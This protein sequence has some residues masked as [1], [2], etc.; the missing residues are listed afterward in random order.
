[1]AGNT[2][3]TPVYVYWSPVEID[4]APLHPQ[5]QRIR[6]AYTLDGIAT[7]ELVPDGE[8][9]AEAARVKSE[10]SGRPYGARRI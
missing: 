10:M 2:N 8:D 7:D 1:M 5:P 3:Q 9:P 4:E 6:F